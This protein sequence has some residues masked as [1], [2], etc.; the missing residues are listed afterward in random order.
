MG[1]IREVAGYVLCSCKPV[2]TVIG[3]Q[4]NQV[5]NMEFTSFL[6][7][8]SAYGMRELEN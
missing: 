1:L 3:P 8:F 5:P 6:I 2:F 4:K 7:G